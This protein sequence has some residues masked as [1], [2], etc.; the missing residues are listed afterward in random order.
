MSKF[1]NL[2]AWAG[3]LGAVV[4]AGGCGSGSSTSDP[5]TLTVNGD[6]A[7]AYA[8]RVNTIGMNPLSAGPTAPGGDLMIREKSSPSAV[9]HNITAQ[10]T[11]GKGDVM[12]PDVSYDGKKVVFSMRC[13]A[14]NPVTI[15]GQ[16]ACTGH[17]NIWEYDMTA[18]GIT[19]GTFR[20]LTSSSGDDIEATYLPAGR[21]FVFTSNRQ[22]KSR[23]TQ[24]LGYT[25]FGLDE[26]ERQQVANLHT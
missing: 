26:Y 10:F 16:P 13:P 3:A 14:S 15:N 2:G 23:V 1:R 21:G 8:Q 20:R 17:W 6:V 19:G 7:I 24:A 25:Y 18:G 4:V 11:M 22:T 5:S 9:E 12:S